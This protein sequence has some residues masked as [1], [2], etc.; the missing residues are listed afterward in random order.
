MSTMSAAVNVN[1]ARQSRVIGAIIAHLN[2]RPPLLPRVLTH[3]NPRVL[4]P[5]RPANAEIPRISSLES[6]KNWA[7]STK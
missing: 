2:L 6:D 3:R 7:T 1:I 5:S 4:S